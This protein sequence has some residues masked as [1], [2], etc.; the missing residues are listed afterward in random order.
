MTGLKPVATKAKETER[1]KAERDIGE[2]V[3]P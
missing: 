2:S 3:Y 1:A